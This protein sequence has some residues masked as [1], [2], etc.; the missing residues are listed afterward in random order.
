MIITDVDAL[1]LRQ[2]VVDATRAD[3]GQ[4]TLLV[5]IHTDSGLVGVGEVDSSPEVT[6]AVIDAPASHS[7][8]NGLRSLLLGRDPLDVIGLWD[9]LYRGSIYAGRRGAGIHALSGVDMALWD[10]KGQAAGKSISALLSDLMTPRSP[11]PAVRVYASAL[12]EQ[13]PELVAERVRAVH[14]MGFTALKLGWGPLGPD[15]KFDAKL[16]AAARAA[17]GD[18]MDL[19]LDAGYGYGTDVAA[20]KYVGDALADLAFLWLE[21]PFL[22]DAVETYA[23]LTAV[24]RVPVAA[25]EQNATRFEF[26]ELARLNALNVWQP[27]VSRCG[28]ITEIM[29][30]AELADEHGVWLVPHAWKSG[31]LKAASLHVNA[32]IAGERLQ[33]WSIAENPLQQRL[34]ST[35]LP[36]VDGQ[37]AVPTQPG[38]GV[39]VDEAIVREYLVSAG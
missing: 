32:V 38:L 31:I 37:A 13:T 27:D 21:E 9:D 22:P 15:P 2:P 12:M 20:A 16:A 11:R 17:A 24:S 19:M 26:L 35:P 39:R 30:I 5:R 8:H 34:V 3:G 4:D 36:I 1:I 14:D 28:G 18:D 23:E 29:R 6:K 33:E 7:V 10:I 25:G